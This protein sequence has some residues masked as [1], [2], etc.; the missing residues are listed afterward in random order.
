[1]L[2][3]SLLG[4]FS[5]E[6][7]VRI[8]VYRIKFFLDPM[9]LI[10]AFIVTLDIV[11]TMLEALLGDMGRL[12]ILRILRL[13]RLSRATLIVEKVPEL[14]MLARSLIGA[15]QPIFWGSIILVFLLAA[16]GVLAVQFIHPLNEELTNQGF[17]AEQRCEK[18][19]RAY[20]AVWH[21]S[22]MMI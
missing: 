5:I 7:A 13:L 15:L 4:V 21:S 1:M 8:Y 10:D 22:L 17:Y 6:L 14:S 20:K 2:N 9:C 3:N 11:S 16:W 19:P 18:C 12:S